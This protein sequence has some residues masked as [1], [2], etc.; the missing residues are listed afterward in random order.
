[1][2]FPRDVPNGA[3][4]GGEARLTITYCKERERTGTERTS[5]GFRPDSA[6]RTPR[7]S[8]TEASFG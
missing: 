8:T 2:N 5:S 3:G 6:S 1:M 4:G 7:V